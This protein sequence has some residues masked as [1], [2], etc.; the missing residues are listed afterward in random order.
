MRSEQQEPVEPPG[1]GVQ[2]LVILVTLGVGG[3]GVF[4]AIRGRL[5][6]EGVVLEG[7]P[8]RIVGGMLVTLAAVSLVRSIHRWRKN[9]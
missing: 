5:V 3:Y 1:L 8:A 2:I 6:S 9:R 4:C 7:T